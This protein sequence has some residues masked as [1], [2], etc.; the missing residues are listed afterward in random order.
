MELAY[1]ANSNNVGD[2]L[3]TLI[4][5][6]LLGEI[7]ENGDGNKLF[8]IG[9]LLNQR[10]CNHFAGKNNFVLFVIQFDNKAWNCPSN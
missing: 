7:L 3:N 5:P 8:G 9:T 6:A 4:W 1:F 10:F 2:E